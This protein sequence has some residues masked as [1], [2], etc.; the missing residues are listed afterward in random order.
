MMGWFIV[1]VAMLQQ[2]APAARQQPRQQIAN[3]R[4]RASVALV[5]MG[6]IAHAIASQPVS[7]QTS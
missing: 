7:A 4:R 6:R 1:T 5:I 3:Q 2:L